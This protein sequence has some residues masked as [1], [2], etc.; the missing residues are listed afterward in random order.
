MAGRMRLRVGRS[1]DVGY[2]RY[3][4]GIGRA[5]VQCTEGQSRGRGAAVIG[6]P[7]GLCMERHGFWLAVS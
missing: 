1:G 4:C 7:C 6:L 2:M 5:L 3:W